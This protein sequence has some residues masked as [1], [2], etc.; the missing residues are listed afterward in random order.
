MKNKHI[1]IIDLLAFILFVISFT[2]LVLPENE[3][4][5]FLLGLP[6]TL[7]VGIA[8]SVIFVFLAYLVSINSKKESDVN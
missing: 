6:Y 5:P 4:N 2:P 3:M 1:R 8:V 7:W